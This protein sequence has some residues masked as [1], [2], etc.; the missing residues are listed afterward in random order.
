MKIDRHK[1]YSKY[2]G[3]CAYCGRAITYKQMQ[4]DHFWPK[5]LS[6]LEPDLDNDRF[7]NLMPSCRKCN[8]HKHGMRPEVWR[9]ELSLVVPRMM[10][11]GKQKSQFN[12]A[13]RFGQIQ[14]TENPIVFYF[15]KGKESHVEKGRISI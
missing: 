12:C 5:F 6:H 11:G 15:E 3:R 10:K 14:I 8:I 2:G 1:V 9:K 13:L 7:E 4:V